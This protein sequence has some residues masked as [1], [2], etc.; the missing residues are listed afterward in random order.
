[1]EIIIFI[2]FYPAV[3]ISLQTLLYSERQKNGREKISKLK[4]AGL[5]I[6]FSKTSKPSATVKVCGHY[7]KKQINKEVCSKE[8]RVKYTNTWILL[9]F[10][11]AFI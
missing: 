7:N 6:I 11:M 9:Y 8:M 4:E 5:V 10:K 3:Y 2:H 1:M